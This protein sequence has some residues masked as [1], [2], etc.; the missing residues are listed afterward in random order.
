MHGDQPLADMCFPRWPGPWSQS[1]EPLPVLR[2]APNHPTND[3]LRADETAH[4]TTMKYIDRLIDS[5]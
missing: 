5:R 2:C 1:L 3:H 4:L